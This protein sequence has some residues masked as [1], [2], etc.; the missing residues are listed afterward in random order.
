M[1]KDFVIYE[2]AP[3]DM[4]VWF[5]SWGELD[6][7]CR[8]FSG[9]PPEGD[10]EFPVRTEYREAWARGRA[11]LAGEM[12]P[13]LLVSPRYRF[14]GPAGA[15]TP[16]IP[17]SRLMYWNTGLRRTTIRAITKPDGETKTIEE[18]APALRHAKDLDQA[19]FYVLPKKHSGEYVSQI[20]WMSTEELT[21]IRVRPDDE[22][23]YSSVVELVCK[24]PQWSIALH[25]FFWIVDPAE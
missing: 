19:P 12:D 1:N 5:N 8:D 7:V 6:G 18:P 22:S 10:S 16:Q 23:T 24:R 13:R 17:A 11:L 14:Q 25:V 20:R 3:G 2:F 9:P 21:D 15:K 4:R